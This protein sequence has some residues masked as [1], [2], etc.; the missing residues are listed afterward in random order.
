MAGLV[1]IWY[2]LNIK[3]CSENNSKMQ[4]Y[5]NKFTTFLLV[6]SILAPQ[7]IPAKADFSALNMPQAGP[8]TQETVSHIA[9]T[10][11]QA[12]PAGQVVVLPS[13][14]NFAPTGCSAVPKQTNTIVQDAGALNLNQTANCFSLKLNK[15]YQTRSLSVEPLL[16]ERAV[17]KVVTPYSA[18]NPFHLAPLAVADATAALIVFYS[19]FFGYIL[20]ELKKLSRK[21][22][23]FKK[24]FVYHFEFLKLNSL[25]C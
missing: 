9:I 21:K 4:K 11:R 19:L 24:I 5:L 10:V 3:D 17:V 15:N 14:I 6:L 12:L 1:F 8:Q 20:A 16:A 25:K 22:Q 2:N 13:Q 23:F 18:I 7:G